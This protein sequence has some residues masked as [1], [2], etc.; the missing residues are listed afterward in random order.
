[1]T[2]EAMSQ[3]LTFFVSEEKYALSV[4]NVREVLEFSGTKKIPGMAD[5]MKGIINLRGSV[6]PVIDLRQKF[7]LPD[8]AETRDTS[9]VVAEI[10]FGQNLV[11]TG[12][13][14]DSVEEVI[15]LEENAIEPA[16][17]IGTT[18]NSH[19]IKGMGKYN[20][21]FLIILNLENLFQE[22]EIDTLEQ[23]RTQG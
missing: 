3:Y 8:L 23:I 4:N 5:F 17:K 16:P 12:L 13:L 18:V 1:M 20:D 11:V 22:H 15:D 14:T 7:G 21:D 2:N 19:F 10:L 9:I 6:V